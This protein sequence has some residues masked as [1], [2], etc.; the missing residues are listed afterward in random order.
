MEPTEV[1]AFTPEADRGTD[2]VASKSLLFFFGLPG[3]GKSFCGRLMEREFGYRFHEGDAW[4]PEDLRASLRR[5]QGFTPEQRDRFAAA[6]ADRIDEAKLSELRSLTP[7]PLAVAQAVFKRRH[8]DIIRKRHPEAKFVWVRSDDV[9][10]ERLAARGNLVD[11]DLGR[12]MASDFEPPSEDEVLHV[13]DNG[14]GTDEALLLQQ[15][16][17]LAVASAL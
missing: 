16:R 15:V 12:R 7:R 8:R 13:I 3:A 9:R 2:A 4:L 17:D 5:G 14:G 6:I 1:G 11:V 10:F